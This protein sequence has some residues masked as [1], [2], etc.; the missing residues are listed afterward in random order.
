MKPALK[1]TFSAIL[2]ALASLVIVIGIA[3]L[4]LVQGGKRLLPGNSDTTVPTLGPTELAASTESAAGGASTPFSGITAT[5]AESAGSATSSPLGRSAPKDWVPIVV[6][7]NQTL[8]DIASQFNTTSD[9]LQQGN[10]LKDKT[11]QAGM[12]LYVPLTAST[13]PTSQGTTTQ[14]GVPAGWVYYY[15]Q[16]GDTLYGIA[17]AFG[18]SVNQLMYANCLS[19]T[20][21]YIGQAL[22]VPNVPPYFGNPGPILPPLTP[23]PTWITF[24]ML[25]TPQTPML[26]TGI[27]FPLPAP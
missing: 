9:A 12:I 19:T 4:A 17:T 26:P 6:Q 10:S 1:K 20:T 5:P 16:P 7:P 23:V 3:S 21:I 22:Y 27:P 14:C 11:I 2:I 15:V 24:P 8:E 25:L 18:I 13:T